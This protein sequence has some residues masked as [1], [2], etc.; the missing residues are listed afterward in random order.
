VVGAIVDE[1]A[2]NFAL[3]NGLYVLKIREEEEKLDVI[4]PKPECHAW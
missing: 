1:G 2:K 4:E 3:E